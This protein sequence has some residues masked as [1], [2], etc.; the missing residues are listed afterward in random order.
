MSPVE[1]RPANPVPTPS[2]SVP[3]RGCVTTSN[4]VPSPVPPVGDG[5]G[6]SGTL[7]GAIQDHYLTPS[8]RG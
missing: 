3:G 4:P 1:P 5:D 2:N 8:G 7:V 6:V